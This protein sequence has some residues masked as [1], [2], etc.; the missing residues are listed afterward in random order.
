MFDLNLTLPIFVGMFI[1]FMAALKAFVLKPVGNVIEK[2][3]AKIRQ[4]IEAGNLARQKAAEIL[5]EYQTR[6]H[7]VRVEAQALI[8]EVMGKAEQV[9]QSE[10]KK[11]QEEAQAKIQSARQKIAAERTSLVDQL[12]EEEKVLVQIITK[13]LLGDDAHISLDSGTVRRALEEAR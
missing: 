12:V 3:Q 4:D 8:N 11:V 7:A 2:R 6:L 9:R 1:A 10:I 5:N 13:K